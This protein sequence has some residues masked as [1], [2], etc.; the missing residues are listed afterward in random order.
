VGAPLDT[1]LILMLANLAPHKG[2]ETAIRAVAE[3]KRR[4]IEVV[5]W[6]A[7]EVRG[8]DGYLGRLRELIRTLG[9]ED[10]VELLGFRRDAAELLQAADFFLLPSTQE[11]LPLCVLEA[12]ASGVPVLA[13]ATAGI[14]EIIRD[15]E[16]GFLIP[17]SEPGA[18]AACLARLLENH[19]LRRQ[20]AAQALAVATHEYNWRR[21]TNRVWELYR[22]LLQ[23]RECGRGSGRTAG[24]LA[25]R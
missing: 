24:E 20:I 6:L 3:L 13:S 23:R 10:R 9:V 8:A 25:P 5:C 15:G 12:Q 14:P 7:G 17:P 21:F 19:D 16:T 18:Y 11:G 4:N 22:E 2:Q 1:P